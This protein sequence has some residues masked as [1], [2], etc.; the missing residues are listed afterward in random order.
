MFQN[1][2]SAWMKN[3]PGEYGIRQTGKSFQCIRRIGKHDICLDRAYIQ[4]I[5]HVVSDN[6]NTTVQPESLHL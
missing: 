2:I 4:K 1:E 5:E 6:L 3:V